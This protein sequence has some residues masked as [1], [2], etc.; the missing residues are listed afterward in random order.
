[1]P[2]PA[3]IV[4]EDPALVHGRLY[5]LGLSEAVLSNAI[6]AGLAAGAACTENHPPIFPGFVL[7]AESVRFLRDALSPEG[8]TRS[9]SKGFA[10]VI[11]ADR[12]LAIAV[13]RGDEA[14]GTNEEG[15][16]P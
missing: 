11:S 2:A 6:R 5:E 3:A 16:V 8:W 15:V 13:A 4:V 14:T 9:D 10:T 7:W 12:R 1:M